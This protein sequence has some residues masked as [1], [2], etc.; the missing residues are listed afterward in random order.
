MTIRGVF[1]HVAKNWKT[2]LAGMLSTL[3]SLSAA[4]FFAPNPFINT[5][6]SGY[7]LAATAMARIALGLLQKDGGSQMNVAL[8]P[9]TRLHQDTTIQTPTQ[10][11]TNNRRT[12]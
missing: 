2:T 9:G 10:A 1:Q 8:P 3:V 7:C 12:P 6:V 4:G 11:E 5:K